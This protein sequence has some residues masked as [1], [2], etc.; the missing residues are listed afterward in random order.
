MGLK[1][2]IRDIINLRCNGSNKTFASLLGINVSTI[3]KWD[4]DHAP[5]GDILLRIYEKFNVDTTWL[6]TGKGDISHAEYKKN[7]TAEPDGLW[8]KTDVVK[9]GDALYNVTVYGDEGLSNPPQQVDPFLQAVGYLKE[10]YDYR[11]P[12]IIN[13][14]HQNLKTFVRTVQREKTI[15]IQNRKIIDLEKRLDKIEGQNTQPKNEGKI[16]NGER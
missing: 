2:R 16:S 12:D 7:I 6:L 13:A 15:S 1:E 10:I 11:D 3:Q 8:G 9:S 14:I 5:N 4:D